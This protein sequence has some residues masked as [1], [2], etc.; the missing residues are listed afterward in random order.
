MQNRPDRHDWNGLEDYL[1]V[2]HNWLRSW[3][4][5]ILRDALTFE[6]HESQALWRGSLYCDGNIEIRVSRLQ[7]VKRQSGKL[8]VRTLRYSY[9][10]RQNVGRDTRNLFRYDNIGQHGAPDGHHRHEYDDGREESPPKAISAED[11]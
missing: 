9:H 7:E 4:H 1:S 5:F 6:L 2:H 10:V 11:W 3:E 8:L